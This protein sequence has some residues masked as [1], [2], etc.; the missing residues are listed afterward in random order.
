MATVERV[1]GSNLV[2]FWLDEHI[3][4]D[5]NCIELKEKF[6]SNTTS[7]YLFHDV[8]QCLQFLPSIG[9]KKLFCIIQG[10]HA[11]TVVPVIENSAT[12]PVVYIFCLN[13]AALNE[14]AQ[15]YDCILNGGIFDHEDDL[16]ARLTQDLANYA[17]LKAQ[18]YRFKR[19]AC[20]DWAA[21]LTKSAKRFRNEQCT[22]PYRTDPFSDQETLGVPPE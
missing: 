1:V 9:D 6:E 4:Q 17:N 11:K 3:C 8:N 2:L 16:L 10:K 12:S 13:V 18:E 22:L 5:K 15:G 7:I 20:E 14:W 21:N 19:E